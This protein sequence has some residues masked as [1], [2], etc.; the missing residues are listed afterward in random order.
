MTIVDNMCRSYSPLGIEWGS[1]FVVYVPKP[2]QEAPSFQ[3]LIIPH[4]LPMKMKSRVNAVNEEV[5]SV[6]HWCSNGETCALHASSAFCA[7][8]ATEINQHIPVLPFPLAPD[9][10]HDSQHDDASQWH[11]MRELKRQPIQV[12][13]LEI[14]IARDQ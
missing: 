13:V 5:I 2:P 11:E 6:R 14:H 12:V 10:Q 8:A 9:I 1:F 7:G 4:I 3:S